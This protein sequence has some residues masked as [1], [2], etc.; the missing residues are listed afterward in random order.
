M[1]APPGDLVAKAMIVAVMGS[2]QGYREFVAYF[3]S[4][5]AGLGEP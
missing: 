5:C 1:P 4:H 3:A 2:A